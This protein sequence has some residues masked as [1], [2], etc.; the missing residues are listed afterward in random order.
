MPLNKK[1]DEE[2]KKTIRNKVQFYGI[3]GVMITTA[4]YVIFE[5]IWYKGKYSAAYYIVTTVLSLIFFSI[6]AYFWGHLN[7]NNKRNKNQH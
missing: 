1:M 6:I 4:F 3:S 5:M 2:Y 7:Y